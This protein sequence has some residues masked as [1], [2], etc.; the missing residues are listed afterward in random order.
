MKVCD[1][2]RVNVSVGEFEE[3]SKQPPLSEQH[4]HQLKH[5]ELFL[6]RQ[7]ESLPATHIRYVCFITRAA[8]KFELNTVGVCC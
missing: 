3:E 1:A 5:R 8:L 6:S 4:K 2:C 7:F